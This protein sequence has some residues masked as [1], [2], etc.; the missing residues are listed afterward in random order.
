MIFKLVAAYKCCHSNLNFLADFLLTP[1]TRR[2]PRSTRFPSLVLTLFPGVAWKESALRSLIP[3][4]RM[5]SASASSNHGRRRCHFQV[6][7]YLTNFLAS[8]TRVAQRVAGWDLDSRRG[9][10]TDPLYMVAPRVAGW[11][12]DSW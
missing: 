10:G 7:E 9:W 3:T 4:F 12:L 5:C 11:D 1:G 2:I 8:K 6:A